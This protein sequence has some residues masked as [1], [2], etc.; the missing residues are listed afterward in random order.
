MFRRLIDSIRCRVVAGMLLV[1]AATGP[2]GAQMG[3]FPEPTVPEPTPQA[4]RTET[5]PLGAGRA[6]RD[7]SSQLPTRPNGSADAGGFGPRSLARWASQTALPLL[8]VVALIVALA[9]LA[10]KVSSAGSGLASQ[11]GAG[12]RAPSGVLSVLGRYPMGPGQTL[13]LLQLDRRILLVTM[14]PGSLMRRRPGSMTTI[15]EITDA[16]EV[17]SIL[18]KCQDERHESIS[19]RFKAILSGQERESLE[20]PYPRSQTIESV[21]PTPPI[22]PRPV[23]PSAVTSIR[24]R[25]ARLRASTEMT[26]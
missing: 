8:G 19:R 23:E 25:L 6:E 21:R 16:E 13:A 5:R 22:S 9:A 1:C 4:S 20:G 12:G 7:S 24:D 11:M 10:R 2:C 18:V 17:A 14:T 3:P 26:R 15:S